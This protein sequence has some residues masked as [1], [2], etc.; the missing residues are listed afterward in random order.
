MDRIIARLESRFA[1][2]DKS[3]VVPE[4]EAEAL[5]VFSPQEVEIVLEVAQHL[6]E[7]TVRC[8]S[9]DTT[10]GLTRGLALVPEKGVAPPAL[11]LR[12]G[13]AARGR[14]H[15]LG[16]KLGRHRGRR[17]GQKVWGGRVE[18]LAHTPLYLQSGRRG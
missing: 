7:N 1:A 11:A 6:G 13:G 17:R 5:G 9:M 12:G 4:E 15:G 10:D 18:Q 3:L 14:R 16:L 8:I 2:A